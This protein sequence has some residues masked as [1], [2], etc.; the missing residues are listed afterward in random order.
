MELELQPIP[1]LKHRKYRSV[2][3]VL[4]SV[5]LILTAGILIVKLFRTSR[6]VGN[7]VKS[8]PLN[9][10]TQTAED[11]FATTLSFEKLES[12]S[13]VRIKFV[14]IKHIL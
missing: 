1:L 8:E 6:D 2:L 12:I 9:N 7:A 11:S 13:E 5:A 14:V 10:V 3:P 4:I